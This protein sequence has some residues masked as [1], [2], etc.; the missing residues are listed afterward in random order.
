MFTKMLKYFRI[1][2]RFIHFAENSSS[3][4]T[5]RQVSGP[6]RTIRNQDKLVV[7]VG[8]W[9]GWIGFRIYARLA[10]IPTGFGWQSRANFGHGWSGDAPSCYQSPYGRSH[11]A[12]VRTIS[13]PRQTDASSH[14]A[15]SCGS[16][17]RGSPATHENQQLRKVVCRTRNHHKSGEFSG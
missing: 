3:R 10:H 2:W 1:S 6:I 8:Y 16:R 13:I 14:P 5:L 7:W 15:K 17:T 4:T 12:I 11:F 9:S